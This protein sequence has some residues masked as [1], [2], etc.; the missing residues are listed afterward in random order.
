M[1][2]FN[3]FVPLKGA[4]KP[5]ECAGNAIHVHCMRAVRTLQA[6]SKYLGTAVEQCLCRQVII[7]ECEQDHTTYCTCAVCELFVNK[8]LRYIQIVNKMRTDAIL[9][10]TNYYVCSLEIA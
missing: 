8:C 1:D 6:C 2:F 5:D 4:Y 10:L 7:R 9:T 3:G